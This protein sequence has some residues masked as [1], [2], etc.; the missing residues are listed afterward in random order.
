MEMLVVLFFG[1]FTLG[2]IGIS[3]AYG[4][5]GARLLI[6]LRRLLG[7]ALFLGSCFFFLWLVGALLVAFEEELA[8][9]LVISL[10]GVFMLFALERSIK[11]GLLLGLSFVLLL[12]GIAHYALGIGLG[13]IIASIVFALILSVGIGAGGIAL[14]KRIRVVL[15]IENLGSTIKK[16]REKRTRDRA[17]VREFEAELK[18]WQAEGYDVSEL[19]KEWFS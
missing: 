5:I 10:A 13:E 7:L 18:Q 11:W 12:A 3:I 16:A 2:I 8:I 1:G 9:A 14:G 17:K 6:Y 4:Y 15:W 19:W